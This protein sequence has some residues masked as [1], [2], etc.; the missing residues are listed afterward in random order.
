MTTDHTTAQ[1]AAD[2]EAPR[3]NEPPAPQISAEAIGRAASTMCVNA[4]RLIDGDT[5]VSALTVDEWKM[6]ASVALG[7]GAPIA[8]QARADAVR[9]AIAGLREI[10]RIADCPFYEHRDALNGISA[11][12]AA[13]L[14][15]IGGSHG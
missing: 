2:M 10:Q 4:L 11:N 15:L 14:A 7:V 6:L 13:I 1:P 8:A 5:R 3:R 12:C 9:E